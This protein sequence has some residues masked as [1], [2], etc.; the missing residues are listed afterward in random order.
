MNFFTNFIQEESLVLMA[1]LLISFLIGYATARLIGM[2][3]AKALKR[4]LEEM[5]QSNA[6]LTEDLKVIN[7]KY[8]I[9]EADL[10]RNALDLERNMRQLQEQKVQSDKVVQ[11]LDATKLT[12]QAA[13]TQEIAQKEQVQVLQKALASQQ[14]ELDAAILVIQSEQEATEELRKR[15]GNIDEEKVSHLQQEVTSLR[16]VNALIEQ[17]RDDLQQQLAETGDSLEMMLQKTE[18]EDSKRVYVIGKSDKDENAILLSQKDALKQLEELIGEVLPYADK[19]EADDLKLINGI[20]PFIEEKLNA[21]GIY[22]YEQ[23]AMFDEDFINVLTAAIGF[24][25]ERIKRGRWVEQAHEFWNEKEQ[26]KLS[27][28]HRDPDLEVSSYQ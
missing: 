13:A 8:T 18:K 3:H 19:T 16:Y 23:I 12:L 7:G 1:F 11:E 28:P 27:L 4:K 20:G 22:T 9:K 6:S 5:S 25:P 24:F 10:K 21:V 26:E 15:L 2:R 14:R 17:E